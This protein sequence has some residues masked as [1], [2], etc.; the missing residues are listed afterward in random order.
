MLSLLGIAF[1][2]NSW[3]SQVIM[4]KIDDQVARDVT[5]KNKDAVS[6]CD[7]KFGVRIRIYV[8]VLVIIGARQSVKTQRYQMF[9]QQ[10]LE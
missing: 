3:A 2:V 9:V 1:I 6:D 10:E 8:R 4:I 7:V 5:A